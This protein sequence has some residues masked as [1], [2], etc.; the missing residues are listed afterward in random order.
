M[1]ISLQD[2]LGRRIDVICRQ[3]TFPL[4]A[5]SSLTIGT[6][7]PAYA[8]GANKCVIWGINFDTYS[9]TATGFT[10]TAG[11]LGFTTDWVGSTAL[12]PNFSAGNLVLFTQASNTYTPGTSFVVPVT[13]AGASGSTC[14]V[15]VL[16][17]FE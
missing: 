8:M 14:T 3:L 16:G 4:G 5:T 15:T 2:V 17:W 12:V 13:S 7:L 1:S 11:Q 10:V 6:L 9:S